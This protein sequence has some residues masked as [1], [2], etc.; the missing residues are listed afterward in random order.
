MSGIVETLTVGVGF[1]V[2]PSGLGEIDD[3]ADGFAS[4]LEDKLGGINKGLD[5]LGKR[6]SRTSRGIQG[7][8]S[9]IALVDPRAAQAVRAVGT[10]ARGLTVLRL[11]LGPAAIAVGVLTAALAIYQHEQRAA[12][13]AAKA[14]EERAK[15]LTEAMEGQVGVTRDLVDEF[16]LI[17]GE[18]DKFGLAAARRADTI[19]ESGQEIL[20]ALDEEIAAQQ[21]QLEQMERNTRVSVAQQREVRALK[22]ELAALTEQR[23][24]EAQNI[25]NQLAVNDALAEYRREEIAA[26]EAL[27]KRAQERRQAE[28]DAQRAA[29]D[30]ARMVNEVNAIERTATIAV[31]GGYDRLLFTYNEQIE[32]LAEIEEASKGAI[33]TE[34]ARAAL[35]M[36]HEHEIAALRQGYLDQLEARRQQLHDMEMERT[37]QQRRAALDSLDAIGGAFGVLAQTSEESARRQADSNREGAER[38]L[39]T[40]KRLKALEATAS[41]AAGIMQA[42][43]KGPVIGT[44]ESAALGVIFGTQLAAINRLSLHQGGRATDEVPG[45]AGSTM[46]RY[47]AQIGGRVLSPEATRRLEERLVDMERGQGMGGQPMI[48]PV[49]E[50]FG[51]FSQDENRRAS[52]TSA[53]VNRGRVVGVAPY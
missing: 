3:V 18:A 15:D 26:N 45:P 16:R 9:V 28:R 6:S 37:E 14:A 33:D 43:S 8:A 2:D 30:R 48:M 50:H 11:G 38:Q 40:T 7:L 53:A 25:Q 24:A 32:K 31:L 35:T 5:D 34:A 47:E 12:A 27:R 42:Y 39:Q 1:A 51:R 41:L 20:D 4:G 10:L 23:E 46:T 19:R 17:T 52:P 44:I 21:A 22:D 29:A 36:Q 13:E 49:Y